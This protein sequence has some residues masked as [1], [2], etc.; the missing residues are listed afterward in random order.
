MHNNITIN[1]LLKQKHM[2][3]KTTKSNKVGNDYS[4]K[5]ICIDKLQHAVIQG[6][7]THHKFYDLER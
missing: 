3:T 5:L 6:N 2:T 7:F 4:M 1:I